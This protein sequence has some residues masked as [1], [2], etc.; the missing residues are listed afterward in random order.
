V[1]FPAAEILVALADRDAAVVLQVGQGLRRAELRQIGRRGAQH[2]PVAGDAPL[3]DIALMH[4]AETDVEL[5]ALLHQIDRAVEQLH[6]D[7]QLRKLPRQLRQGRGQAAAAETGAAADAQ[8]AA[9]RGLFAGNGLAHQVDIFEDALRPLMDDLALGRQRHVARRAMEKF[10]LHGCFEQGHALADH[11]LGNTQFAGGFGK[12]A[13]T[14]H[15]TEQ[16]EVFELGLYVHDSC[17]E[18]HIRPDCN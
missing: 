13:V 10:F 18:I 14:G 2:P 16:A 17:S 4:V 5:E 1:Q 9:R 15:D 7:F 8:Q 11:G 6:L 12:A 3:D